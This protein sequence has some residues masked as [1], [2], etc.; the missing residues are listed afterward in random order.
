MHWF[1][2]SMVWGNFAFD[3]NRDCFMTLKNH[4]YSENIPSL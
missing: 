2:H 4:E 1:R 3:Q